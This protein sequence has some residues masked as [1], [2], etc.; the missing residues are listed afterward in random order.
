[1]KKVKRIWFAPRKLYWLHCFTVCLALGLCEAVLLTQ[2]RLPVFRAKTDLIQ[3]D[4]VVLDKDGKPVRGLTQNDFTLLEDKTQQRIEGFTA[5]DLE[6]VVHDAGPVWKHSVPADV[7]TNEIDNQ[8]IFVLVVDDGRSMGLRESPPR[9]PDLWAIK[10]MKES[11]ALFISQLNPNDLVALFFTQ[12]TKLS[13][14]LTSDHAR[15]IKAV[16]SF[17][18]GGGGDLVGGGLACLGARYAVRGMKGIIEQLA[19]IPDR[20]KAIV[21]FGGE[22]PGLPNTPDDCGIF[23]DWREVFA[24]ADQAHVTVNPVDTMGLRL[25]GIRDNYLAVAENTGG[26][27]IVATNDFAP[28]IRRIFVENSSYYLLAYSPTRAEEDGTF[29]RVTVKV[30]GRPD[31]EVSS[32]R[33]YWAPKAPKPGDPPPLPPPPDVEAL[34]GLLPLSK[35][36][37]RVSAAAFATPGVQSATVTL[38]LG[39][40][41]PAFASRTSEQ[42]ELLVKAYTADGDQLAS[43]TQLIPITVPAAHADVEQSRYEVLAR[44]DL[45]KPGKYEV[46]LSAK[47]VASDTRGSVY[48]DVEVPDYR[49]EKVSLSGVVLSSALP[50]DPVAPLRVLRDVVPMVP[51]SERAFR[52]TDVVTAFVRAYQG[53]ND[54]FAPVTMKVTIQDAAGKRVV[55]KTDTVAADTFT[56]DRSADYQFRLP[57][58]ALPAGEYLLTLEASV[59]KSTAR[60]DVRFQKR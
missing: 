11:V 15:L 30:N 5:V 4:V 2:Q 42:I 43:D 59:G 49:K 21:Y 35:L 7:V 26:R 18:D 25:N 3:L 24:A 53:G 8:R 33:S 10:R 57:L 45:P 55:D 13:Q 12:R 56:A 1:V 31:L 37:L 28:G 58:G 54:K 27:A 48:V 51:T 60:R 20:R 16:Q 39:V 52:A 40:K 50:V 22:L 29:R 34:A 36:P 14:N 46:R 9:T 23:Y 19:T 44:I 32:R 6:D 41:Q 38:A 47:S 17:P